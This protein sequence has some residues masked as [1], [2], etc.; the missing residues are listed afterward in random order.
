MKLSAQQLAQFAERGYITVAALFDGAEIHA[1]RTALA[2]IKASSHQ[3][4]VVR[5]RTNQS[6]RLVYGAHLFDDTWNRLAHHP[7][8][9]EPACQL[10]GGHLYIHQ[11][12]INPKAAFDGQGWWWHQDYATWRFEDG[13]QE[14]RALMIGV[15]LAARTPAN[16]P[17]MVIPGSHTYGHIERTSPD[18]DS[19]GYTV[20]DIPRETIERL[21]QEGGGIEAVTGP[22][23]TVLFMHCNLVHGSTGNIT[24]FERTIAYLNVASVD[25]P[26]RSHRAEWFANRDCS[27]LQ[28]LDDDCL[29]QAEATAI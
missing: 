19:S 9:I 25:N 6:V 27:P 1:L 18:Q 10:L 29:R 28:S 21:V 22:A 23:G 7:R 26:T 24:P 14:P 13:M 5:E 2:R 15:F 11:L 4:Q 8:W 20:M 12:R 17:L 16:G 3:P